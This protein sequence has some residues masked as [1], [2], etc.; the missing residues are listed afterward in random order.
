MYRK[1]RTL[2]EGQIVWMR[3]IVK[4]SAQGTHRHSDERSEIKKPVIQAHEVMDIK[5]FLSGRDALSTD[6]C[7]SGSRMATV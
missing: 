5:Q 6:S 2:C 3:G 1:A 4:N 7:E